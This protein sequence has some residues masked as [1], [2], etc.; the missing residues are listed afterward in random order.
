MNFQ[1]SEVRGQPPSPGYGGPRRSDV[2]NQRSDFSYQVS[3]I[4]SKPS[5][6]LHID[7]LMLH[8]FASSERYAIG[9]AV[10]RELARLFEKQ[11]VPNSLRSEK[12]TDEIKGATFNAT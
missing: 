1:R 12:T 7:E 2:R 11:G 3:A 4:D 10:E 8:G 9:D 5:V 6:E